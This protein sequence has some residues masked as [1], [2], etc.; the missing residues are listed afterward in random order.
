MRP[1][2]SMPGVCDCSQAAAGIKRRMPTCLIGWCIHCRGRIEICGEFQDAFV[3]CPRCGSEMLA[4]AA[5]ESRR[6]FEHNRRRMW[7][8]LAAAVVIC[9]GALGYFYRAQ[10]ASGFDLV[11]EET[12]SATAAAVCLGIGLVALVWMLIWMLFPIVVYLALKDL[13]RRTSELDESTRICARHLARL[14]NPPE[15]PQDEKIRERT[16]DKA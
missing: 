7:I 10:L 4:V 12:G 6:R 3:E 14:N 5:V 8:G 16:S 1:K 11:V 2:G 13:R 9:L 15:M